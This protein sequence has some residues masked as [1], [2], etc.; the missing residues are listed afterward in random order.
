MNDK[1]NVSKDVQATGKE[2][3]VAEAIPRPSMEAVIA[4]P[5]LALCTT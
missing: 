2:G 1:Y 3:G 5:G 4:T